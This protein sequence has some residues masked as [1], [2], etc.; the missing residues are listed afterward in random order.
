MS[1][2]E[3][4]DPVVKERVRTA[5]LN[6]VDQVHDSRRKWARGW[7]HVKQ[8]LREVRKDKD[9][10]RREESGLAAEIAWRREMITADSSVEEEREEVLGLM[11]KSLSEEESDRISAIPD[12]HEVEK[13]VFGMARYKAPGYDGLTTDVVCECWDFVGQDCVKLVQTIWVKKHILRADC[14]G[15][16]KLILKPGEKRFLSNWRPI[17]L[18]TWTYKTFK[19]LEVRM[20][21]H[22]GGN[23]SM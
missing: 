8:V 22:L 5:W 16:I 19:Y 12:E 21:V 4:A 3:L 6:E 13:V 10:L 14:Q 18:M 1:Y 11:N 20:G 23:E 9:G 17:S 15:I 2:F 7:Q